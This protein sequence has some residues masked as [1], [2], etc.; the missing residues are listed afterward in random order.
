[1]FTRDRNSTG[2][3]LIELMIAVA[4]VSILAGIAYPSYTAQISKSRRAAA[5][6]F[7]MDVA[8]RQQQHFV[9]ARRY[10][11]T[12][13]GLSASDAVTQRYTITVTPTVGPP[14][15]FTPAF[16]LTAVPKTAQASDP[17]GT[18]TVRSSGARDPSSCW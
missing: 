12:T 5:Q 1:M 14:P 4:V 3:T 13:L 7:L 17:C 8:S 15:T 16:T 11:S 9:D 6:A 2:F 18:L 10:A